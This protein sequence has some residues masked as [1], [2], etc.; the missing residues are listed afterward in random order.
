ME[1][2][3]NM[4]KEIQVLHFFVTTFQLY[5]FLRCD[6]NFIILLTTGVRL[7]QFL[8]DFFY[9]FLEYFP[10]LRQIN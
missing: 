9:S 5:I 10:I 3:T 8:D 6:N 1:K 2:N 7:I 4:H